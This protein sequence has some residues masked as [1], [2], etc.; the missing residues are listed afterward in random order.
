MVNKLRELPPS[1]PVVPI[2]R[3]KQI[4]R[5][6]L[7]T[8]KKTRNLIK[9]NSEDDGEEVNPISRLIHIAQTRKS[10]EPVYTL[11]EERGAPRRREF[12][13]EVSAI[14]QTAQ[15]VGQTKKL[16]KRQAAESMFTWKKRCLRAILMEKFSSLPDLLISLGYAVRGSPNRDVSSTDPNDKAKRVKFQDASKGTNATNKVV[17]N[18]GGTGGRQLAPGLL[19]VQSD[20]K[21]KL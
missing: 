13:M 6:P 2:V 19:L 9:D 5:K 16:A 11:V 12:V 17:T 4:K 18:Q 20:S 21:G 14:K 7:P 3:V 10:K 8:K 15:G 1:S